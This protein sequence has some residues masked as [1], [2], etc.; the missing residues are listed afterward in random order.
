MGGM[1]SQA[2]NT[3]SFATP[4]HLGGQQNQQSLTQLPGQALEG[5]PP[6]QN[7]HV[8]ICRCGIFS[9]PEQALLALQQ[10]S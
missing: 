3:F 4:T 9:K 6:V 10:I 1:Q 2:G 8:L 5:V 7:E